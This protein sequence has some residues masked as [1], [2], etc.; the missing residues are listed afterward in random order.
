M[1]GD[2]DEP[3]RKIAEQIPIHRL[4]QLSS[5]TLVSADFYHRWSPELGQGDGEEAKGLLGKCNPGIVPIFVDEIERRAQSLKG[6]DPDIVQLRGR[7]LSSSTH[8]RHPEK[9]YDPTAKALEICEPTD[10]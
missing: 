10:I 4:Q 2:E 6:I 8:A 7:E 9:K 1:V 5:H 3:L